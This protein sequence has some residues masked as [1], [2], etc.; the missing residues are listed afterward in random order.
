[1]LA[2]IDGRRA[3]RPQWADYAHD[4]EPCFGCA[5]RARCRT[6]LACESFFS[7]VRFGRVTPEHERRPMRAW[8]VQAFR[9]D[10]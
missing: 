1:V 7:W 5:H 10:D 4:R 6:G 2:D 3:P 8:F 9:A